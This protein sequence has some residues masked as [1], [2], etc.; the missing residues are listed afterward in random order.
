METTLSPRTGEQPQKIAV[1]WT[2]SEW[3]QVWLRL[4]KRDYQGDASADQ[5]SPSWVAQAAAA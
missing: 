3:F 4:A 5:M 2:E 1:D